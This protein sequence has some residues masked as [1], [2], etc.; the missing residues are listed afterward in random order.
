MSALSV[1]LP[2]LQSAATTLSTIGT[3]LTEANAQALCTTE[4]AAPGADE[5]SAAITALFNTHGRD[6][7][8]AATDASAIHQQ[9]VQNMSAAANAY[10]QAEAANTAA[11]SRVHPN[12]PG[13]NILAFQWRQHELRFGVGDE[14]LT[15]RWGWKRIG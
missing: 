8:A 2:A 12:G 5:I 3:E 15:I 14:W 4:I 11:L 10:Q 6:F 9:F 1:T 7:Q 13:G